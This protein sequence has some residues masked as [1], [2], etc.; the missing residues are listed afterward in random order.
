MN[1]EQRKALI[2]A[3][4]RQRMQAEQGQPVEAEEPRKPLFER[5]GV[6]AED[7]STQPSINQVDP[8]AMS[9][10][11]LE[12]GSSKAAIRNF[13]QGM[14][15]N[16]ADEMEAAFRSTFGDKTY[17]ENIDMIRAEMKAYEAENPGS[18]VAQQIAGGVMNPA[19]ALKLPQFLQKMSPLMQGGVVGGSSGLLYGVGGGEGG[20]SERVQSGAVD[21]GIG[22]L[23]GA[24]LQ[25][26]AST[27]GNTKIQSLIS[28]QNTAPT[29]DRLKTLKDEA[30]SLVD[31]AGFVIGPG[32][33]KNI[34]DRAS[35][36]AAEA[37]YIAS[38]GAVTAVDK[39]KKLLES[40]LDKGMT[41][42]QSENIRQRLFKL[43]EGEDGYI[44]R[45][46]I[47]EFDDVI[48]TALGS[49]DSTV[50]KLARSANNSYAKARTVQEAFEAVPSDVSDTTK[51]F[52]KV[53]ERLLKNQKQMKYFSE[54]DKELLKQMSQGTLPNNLVNF[55]GKF[56]PTSNSLMAAL[57]VGVAV[58]N[59]W[60]LL[61]SLATTGSKY[62]A[63]KNTVKMA[64]ELVDQVGG[65][66]KVR[67]ISELENAATISVSGI[68]ADS[69][70]RQLLLDEDEE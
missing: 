43:S 10:G 31:E 70:R 32:E 25:K 48:D 11:G 29:V 38:P 36:I 13:F 27:V 17:E 66:K 54:Q 63:D 19:L 42:G 60:L 16:T 5:L 28:E 18:T 47:G 65:I 45:K 15:F 64:R 52:K 55:F 23:I 12:T 40:L 53:A 21:A 67:E 51:A 44:V 22:I 26:L 50:L 58:T 39:A 41:L 6:S 4:A 24:P 56:S 34:Y 49:G 61:M 37:Q 35:N 33:A 7:I 62:M 30:Y 68:S 3:R 1:D 9:E 59:P 46:M 14:T 20:V 2:R 69:I 8:F 57:N